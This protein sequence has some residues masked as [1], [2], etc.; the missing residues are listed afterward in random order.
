MIAKS[1]MRPHAKPTTSAVAV[2]TGSTI[3]G[4]A[5]WRISFSRRITDVVESVTTAVYHL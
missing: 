5:I 3:F 1:G 2:A 4:N